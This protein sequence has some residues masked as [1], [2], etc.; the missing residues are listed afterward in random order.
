MKAITLT[1]ITMSVLGLFT[2]ITPELSTQTYMSLCLLLI[3]IAMT[4][5]FLSYKI[6]LL[7]E[8]IRLKHEICVYDN[9]VNRL[10]NQLNKL[11]N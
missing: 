10:N 8:I 3:I 9:I 4:I 6:K 1:I 2:P 7:K 5:Y 11:K